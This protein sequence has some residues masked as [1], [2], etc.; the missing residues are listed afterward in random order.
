M[1][2]APRHRRAKAADRAADGSD[3]VFYHYI[4]VS[5]PDST[6]ILAENI[7]IL[8]ISIEAPAAVWY[9]SRKPFLPEISTDGSGICGKGGQTDE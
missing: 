2:F 8:T 4:M 1:C 6:E 7:V 3:P 5:S 9:D